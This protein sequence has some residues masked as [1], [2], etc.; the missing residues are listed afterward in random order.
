[1]FL[2]EGMRLKQTKVI[3]WVSCVA[4][5]VAK[6]LGGMVY[7]SQS[8]RNFDCQDW[9]PSVLL[10]WHDLAANIGW[11]FVTGVHWQ[12]RDGAMFHVDTAPVD[13]PIGLCLYT[14]KVGKSFLSMTL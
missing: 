9:L 14:M 6:I 10:V 7:S 11:D 3:G 1:M 4:E 13:G 2:L 12:R 5:P 8:K